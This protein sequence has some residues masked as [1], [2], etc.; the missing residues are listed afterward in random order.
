[1]QS[2]IVFQLKDLN[3]FIVKAFKYKEIEENYV[4]FK[5]KP[6]IA[7]EKLNHS[8]NTIIYNSSFRSLF[9][10]FKYQ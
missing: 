8:Y 1:M 2:I 6:N 10:T 3:I 7:A 9:A 5:H 4:V